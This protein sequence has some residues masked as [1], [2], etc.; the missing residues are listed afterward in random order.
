[1]AIDTPSS[2]YIRMKQKRK[3]TATLYAG[4]EAMRAARED[5]LPKEPGELSGMYEGRL[6]R[7]F[8]KNYVKGAVHGTRGKIFAC[9]IQV[10]DFTD[11]E[12]V[13]NV[14]MQGTDTTSFFSE[15][16]THGSR[17]GFSLTMVD[18]PVMS[19]ELSQAGVIEN[20]IRPFFTHIEADQILGASVVMV[21]N[22]PTLCD[23]RI[24]E[25][26]VEIDK[27]TYEEKHYQ[28]IRHLQLIVL[29]EEEEGEETDTAD[30]APRQLAVMATIYR[31]LDS[32]QEWEIHTSTAL[33]ISRIPVAPYY[34][35]KTGPFEAEPFFD[36]LA[37]LNLQHWQS[38]SDQN[39][40]LHYVRVPRFYG[41][42]FTKEEVQ[43]LEE[44]GIA[45]FIYSTKPPQEVEAGWIEA[46]GKAIAQG[47]AA[48]DDLEETLEAQSL[49]PM[50]SRAS[51]DITATRT[52]TEAS[53]S[54]SLIQSWA[55]S[56]SA[57]IHECFSLANMFRGVTENNHSV[58]VNDDFDIID[59]TEAKAKEIREWRVARLISHE[60]ALA[61]AKELTS[62][63][64]KETD[65]IEEIE[66]VQ[67]ELP[68]I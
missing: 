38:S 7:S 12:I 26:H 27:D 54:N 63:L 11:E 8:L 59:N 10:N 66:K 68:I 31:R 45:S 48:L 58:T 65:I 1:M 2:A 24:S 19:E 25:S 9:P 28:Q 55:R 62:F 15:T 51:A 46:D 60:T 32:S 34:T 49:E 57:H 21:N 53:K 64:P 41:Y 61:A 50:V 47:K 13:N 39:N 30:A 23:I 20:N 14:D 6:K 35:N 36:D 44:H 16:Y 52:K 3:L 18:S 42:G 5:Y 37:W 22:V 67:R 17:D 56:L 33:N 43:K 4:T 29:G 40:I